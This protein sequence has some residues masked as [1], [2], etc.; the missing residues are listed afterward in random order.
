MSQIIMTSI[1]AGV[2]AFRFLIFFTFEPVPGMLGLCLLVGSLIVFVS[3]RHV[4][5]NGPPHGDV[6]VCLSAPRC[7]KWPTTR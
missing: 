2:Y 7:D 4:V 1:A 6:C 5:T 3:L